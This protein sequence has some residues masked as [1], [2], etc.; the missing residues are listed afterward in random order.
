MIMYHIIANDMANTK[1]QKALWNHMLPYGKL[2]A[3]SQ[4]WLKKKC[5]ESR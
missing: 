1:V 5:A 4:M 2:Y 3:V